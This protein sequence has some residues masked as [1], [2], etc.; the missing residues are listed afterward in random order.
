QLSFPILVVLD[1]VAVNRLV[2]PAVYAK[3]RLP[4]TVQ[5]ELAQSDSPLDRFLEDPRSHASPVPHHFSRQSDVHGHYSHI[6]IIFSACGLVS[7]LTM[8]QRP[9]SPPRAFLSSG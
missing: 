4:V 2:F 7:S 3:V 8:H 6:P 1:G 5:V 9:Q